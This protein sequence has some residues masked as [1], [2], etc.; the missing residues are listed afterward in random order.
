M[1]F[2][3]FWGVCFSLSAKQSRE[4]PLWPLLPIFT[5]AHHGSGGERAAHCV[6]RAFL[7][8][9]AAEA[10]SAHDPWPTTAAQ[11]HRRPANRRGKGAANHCQAGHECI[12]DDAAA[13]EVTDDVAAAVG[14]RSLASSPLVLSSVAAA[15]DA[16]ASE[17]RRLGIWTDVRRVSWCAWRPVAPVVSPPPLSQPRVNQPPSFE[18]RRRSRPLSA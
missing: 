8:G 18:L 9:R 13:L 4:F 15:A 1:C 5:H 11:P 7:S 2:L 17:A 16:G 10:D 3:F 14:V 12:G 6:L